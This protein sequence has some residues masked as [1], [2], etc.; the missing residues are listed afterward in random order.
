MPQLHQFCLLRGK[1]LESLVFLFAFLLFLSLPRRLYYLA[2]SSQQRAATSPSAKRSAAHCTVPVFVRLTWSTPRVHQRSQVFSPSAAGTGLGSY[3]S[4]PC[5]GLN[6]HP[7]PPA[8]SVR[9]TQPP[10]S[11]H[12]CSALLLRFLFHNSGSPPLPHSS[13][14]PSS[15]PCPIGHAAKVHA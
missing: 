4:Q 13:T 2:S 11:P 1:Q 6:S 8:C 10:P 9:Q 12:R 14:L 5:W 3:T 15:I 7:T